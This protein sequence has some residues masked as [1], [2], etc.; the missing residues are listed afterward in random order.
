MVWPDVDM[1]NEEDSRVRKVR[2]SEGGGGEGG[3]GGGGA[4]AD[5]AIMA[6][7]G[8]NTGSCISCAQQMDIDI[9]EDITGDLTE[10][11]DP[12]QVGGDGP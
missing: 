5:S 8:S 11:T 2:D 10:D 6:E 7:A 9:M 12:G 4:D 1:F 3:G